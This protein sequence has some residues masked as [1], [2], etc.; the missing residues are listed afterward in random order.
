MKKNLWLVFPAAILQYAAIGLLSFIFFSSKSAFLGEIMQTVFG[1]N[2]LM[3]LLLLFLFAVLSAIFVIIF[4]VIAVNG[5]YDALFVAKTAMVVKLVQIPAYIGIFVLGALL[6]ISLMTIPF[7]VALMILDFFTLV[8]T[9]LLNVTAVI[10]A[11]RQKLTTWS[12]SIWM[13][14]L[15]L[16]FCADVVAS[17]VLYVRLKQVHQSTQTAM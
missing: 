1:N 3:V 16:V 13:V 15:Q 14:L 12:H 6:I 17:I 11:V 10:L 4:S 7:A 9:G 2:G 8:L 5:E